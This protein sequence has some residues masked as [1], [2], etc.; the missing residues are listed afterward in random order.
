ML[1]IASFFRNIVVYTY[2]VN[3]SRTRSAYYAHILHFWVTS[4]KT[5]P[6]KIFMYEERFG[7]GRV[8]LKRR[9]FCVICN[10]G[11]YL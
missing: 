2:V 4:N 5:G 3:E 6:Y 9:T 7:K 8:N 11:K 1:I 10:P